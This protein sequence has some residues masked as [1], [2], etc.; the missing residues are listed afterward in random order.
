MN[1]EELLQDIDNWKFI[2]IFPG[3]I[4]DKY[5]E[6]QIDGVVRQSDYRDP[7]ICYRYEY[8]IRSRQDVYIFGIV[9]LVRNDEI[10]PE[11]TIRFVLSGIEYSHTWAIPSI[12]DYYEVVINSI[13][14]PSFYMI[15]IFYERTMVSIFIENARRLRIYA[16]GKRDVEKSLRE[17]NNYYQS[18]YKLHHPNIRL[19]CE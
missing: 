13:I 15:D 5:M 6:L 7:R 10:A 12:N 17:Y 4:S 19:V 1:T 3:E 9:P 14:I 8:Y 11:I 18:N 2:A 16:R